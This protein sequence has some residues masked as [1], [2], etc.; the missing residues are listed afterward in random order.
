M[1][2]SDRSPA[3]CPVSTLLGQEVRDPQGREIGRI[4]DLV[5]DAALGCVGYVVLAFEEKLFAIPW[6][7]L[8]ADPASTAVVADVDRELPESAPGLAEDHWP[9]LADIGWRRQVYEYG[10]SKG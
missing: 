4:H 1:A 7:A 9:D 2:T 6:G 5:L 8:R 10:R 3:S